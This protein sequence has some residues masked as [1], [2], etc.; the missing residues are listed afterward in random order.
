MKNKIFAC[1]FVLCSISSIAYGQM[2]ESPLIRLKTGL[3]SV[4]EVEGVRR[5]SDTD[6]ESLL[7][8]N[9]NVKKGRIE[10]VSKDGGL[11]VITVRTS[12][13]EASTYL[14]K[15]SKFKII[16]EESKKVT[17]NAIHWKDGK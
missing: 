17:I 2:Y 12:G 13:K 1:I 8:I 16:G 4:F 11:W 5:I 15:D 6:T 7:N 10:S 3:P 9:V 14:V